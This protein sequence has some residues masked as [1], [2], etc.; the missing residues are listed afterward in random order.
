MENKQNKGILIVIGI[1]AVCF[2]ILL[3]SSGGSNTPKTPS[4]ILINEYLTRPDVWYNAKFEVIKTGVVE[5]TVE[6]ETPQAN[7]IVHVLKPGSKSVQN[8]LDSGEGFLGSVGS[9]FAGGTKAVVT[10]EAK[11]IGDYTL[12]WAQTNQYIGNVQ[13]KIKIVRPT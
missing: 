11:N 6:T 5:I 12:V 7:I 1:I 9:W 13:I 4:R 10:I 2:V 3:L 8:L